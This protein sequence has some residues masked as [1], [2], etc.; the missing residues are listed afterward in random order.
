M[1]VDARALDVEAVPSEILRRNAE[2]NAL[3]SALEPLLNGHRGE[4]SIV[5][6]PSG[7]GKTACARY[8]LHQL[9]QS[10]LDVRTQYINC[11][12]HSSRFATLLQLV[13]GVGQSMDIQQHSTPHDELLR[14]LRRAEDRP[15]VVILDEADQLDDRDGIL[16]ELTQLEHVHFILIANREQDL[17]QGLDRRVVSRL[18][19]CQTLEFD[20]YPPDVLADILERRAEIGLESGAVYRDVLE[21]IAEISAGDARVAIRTLAEGAKQASHD[22]RRIRM[23]YVERANVDAQD[24]LRQK[25]ISQLTR[26]QR[27]LYETMR[28]GGCAEWTIGGIFEPYAETV[29]EPKSKKTVKRYLKKMAHYNLIDFDGDAKG[30]RYWIIK[31]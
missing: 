25:A 22:G 5:Y 4:H 20:P 28:D 24:S 9:R 2:L 3:S 26:H 21:E 23:E 19:G 15:Y 18:R 17:F 10:L 29:D 16:Y 11:W 7:S 30:R 6:G 1:I 27:V 12:Q 14:R 8:T 31:R 13:D